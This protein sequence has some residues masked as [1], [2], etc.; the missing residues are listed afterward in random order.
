[1]QEGESSGAPPDEQMYEKD[2]K[3][4]DDRKGRDRAEEDIEVS[5]KKDRPPRF[6]TIFDAPPRSPQIIERHVEPRRKAGVYIPTPLFVV[7]A[8]VLFF[9]STLLFAYTIIGLY[10][11]LPNGMLPFGS[12]S[13]AVVGGC[14]C[15]GQQPGINF[16]PNFYMP[17][18]KGDA[19]AILSTV[20]SLPELASTHAS[21]TSSTSSSTSKGSTTTETG[22]TAVAAGLLSFLRSNAKTTTTPSIPVT[23]KV[24][25]TTPTRKIVT[26]VVEQT[27]EAGQQTSTTTVGPPTSTNAKRE[28]PTSEATSADTAAAASETTTPSSTPTTPPSPPPTTEAPSPTTKET[29]KASPTTTTTDGVGGV[30]FG[31]G[32]AVFQNCIN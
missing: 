11:N 16:A 17:G 27:V 10:N 29:T 14:D 31:A 15:S 13:A 22:N 1:M 21:T 6:S 7:L 20:S 8:F 9:E 32:G 2:E 25:V 28:G 12:S 3:H 24:I 4:F 30:C 23:T 5:E 19:A 18:A 26:S